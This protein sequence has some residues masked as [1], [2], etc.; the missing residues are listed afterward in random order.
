MATTLDSAHTVQSSEL[1]RNPAS[2]FSE[3][4]AHP[5][6]VTRRDGESLVLMT[7]REAE[8]RNL[9]LEIAA[10]LIAVT[11]DDRGTLAE[12]MAVQFP[13]MYALDPV[14]RAQCADEL[15]K[16]TRASFATNQPNLAVIELTAWRETAIAIAEGYGDEPVEWSTEP[17]PVERPA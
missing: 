4:E 14:D 7:E 10:Q 12:R 15:V 1:S 6:T 13:W 3:A 11:T 17:V 9:L 2:V 16:A 5:I 8:S